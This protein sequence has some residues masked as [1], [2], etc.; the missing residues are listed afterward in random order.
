MVDQIDQGKADRILADGDVQAA[1]AAKRSTGTPT[2]EYLRLFFFRLSFES[3]STL[4]LYP[5]LLF[6]S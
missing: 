1:I 3:L 6:V 2:A 5:F 4:K